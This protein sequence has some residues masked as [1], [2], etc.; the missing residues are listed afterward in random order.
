MSQDELVV[1]VALYLAHMEE[2]GAP[3]VPSRISRR[4]HDLY[5]AYTEFSGVVGGEVRKMKPPTNGYPLPAPGLVRGQGEAADVWVTLFS[6]NMLFPGHAALKLVLIV[7]YT[8]RK[9]DLHA[10]NSII[11]RVFNFLKDEQVA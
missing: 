1:E 4:Q 7:A 2:R 8:D 11:A 9:P 5:A 6:A 3:Y 10:E